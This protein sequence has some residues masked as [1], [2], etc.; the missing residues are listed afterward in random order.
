MKQGA[1]TVFFRVHVFFENSHQDLRPD[2]EY[3][4]EW[5]RNHNFNVDEADFNDAFEVS[6]EIADEDDK[7]KKREILD[8]YLLAISLR[9]SMGFLITDCSDNPKYKSWS[10]IP[11]GEEALK[12]FLKNCNNHIFLNI[13]KKL[14]GFYA[15]VEKRQ[16]II[17][18]V[19]LLEEIFDTKPKHI[20]NESEKKEINK[21]VKKLNWAESKKGK[22]IKILKDVNFM[23]IETR[24]ERMVKEIVKYLKE[25][26]KIIIKRLRKIYK[27]RSSGAHTV[28]EK[29]P[30]ELEKALKEIDIIFEM[31]LI[32]QFKFA[33]TIGMQFLE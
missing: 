16:K 23:A 24:N 25:D 11:P 28:E 12:N 4:I 10:A 14:R 7:A 30:I 27:A 6:F 21:V 33:R 8:Q 5:L 19:A 20:L 3:V 2:P 15:Q 29:D 26:E 9:N 17:L 1:K 13:V 32:Y 18:G 22:V 31:Y